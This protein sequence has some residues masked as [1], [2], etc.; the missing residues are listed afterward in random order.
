MATWRFE[1]SGVAGR[2]EGGVQRGGEDRH[3]EDTPKDGEPGQEPS[4]DTMGRPAEG[5]PSSSPATGYGA[6]HDK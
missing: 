6:P 5:V 4:E 1:D 3:D 2:G